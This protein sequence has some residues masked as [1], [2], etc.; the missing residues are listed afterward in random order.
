MLIILASLVGIIIGLNFK[1]VILIPVFL[2]G[3]AAYTTLSIEYGF[4]A[5]ALAILV[6]AV[7]VQGGYMIGLTG[8]DL[9]AQILTRLNIVQ[10]RRI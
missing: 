2:I 4:G 5:N 8:R 10:S 7:A 9:F 3:V 1:V 6:A